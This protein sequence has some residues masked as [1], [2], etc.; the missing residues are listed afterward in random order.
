MSCDRGGILKRNI[1]EVLFP[2]GTYSYWY[3]TEYFLLLLII[4]I[5]NG[6]VK[7]CSKRK[8]QTVLVVLI[9]VFSFYPT[10][11]FPRVR[12]GDGHNVMWLAVVYMVGIYLKTYADLNTVSIKKLKFIGAVVFGILLLSSVIIGIATKL[13]FGSISHGALLFA[14]NSPLMLAMSVVIFVVINRRSIP[15]C[16]HTLCQKVGRLTFGVYLWHDNGLVR[17]ALWSRLE[18]GK[19][20]II[21]ITII[22]IFLVIFGI[23]VIGCVLEDIRKHIM[24]G[25]ERKVKKL[26]AKIYNIYFEK[27]KEIK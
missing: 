6:F 25:M 2:I 11:Y 7:G 18:L 13:V 17:E 12:F 23:F 15:K 4:P 3:V 21:S 1:L 24:V 19:E 5:I 8:F 20:N 16:L 26:D 14:Y 10:L 22:K 9:G 27:N